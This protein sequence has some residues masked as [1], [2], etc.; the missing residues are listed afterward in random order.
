M[1]LETA[2]D[3]LSR[4]VEQQESRG[5]TVRHVAVTNDEDDGALHATMTVPVFLGT[6]ADDRLEPELPLEAT[7]TDDGGL[8]VEFPPSVLALP[9]TSESAITSR[10]HAVSITDD[11]LCVTVKLTI[12]QT[13]T[14]AR[15]EG[16]DDTEPIGDAP[17]TD[18]P[19]TAELSG[20]ASVTPGNHDSGSAPEAAPAL[21]AVRNEELPPY[22]DTDY[23]R[24]LYDTCETFSEMSQEIAMDVSSETVR[25]YMIDAGIHEPTSYQS[26]TR[27]DRESEDTSTADDLAAESESGNRQTESPAATD[28]AGEASLEEQI[29]TDG[30]GLPDHLGIE[31]VVEAVV[32]STT[33]YEVQRDLDL[34]QRPTR[35]LLR[36]LNLLDLVLHRISEGERDVSYEEV[37]TRIRECTAVAA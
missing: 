25:R 37:A 6:A 4:V 18:E 13:N 9:S 21:E 36:Q 34:E 35:E 27:N 23:L 2:F 16:A 26:Q 30:L 17:G 24:L 3:V 15:P 19:P 10:N 31:D 11:G 28:D 5:R 29:V 12:D 7:V 33:V 32:K 20:R 14:P 8:R 1:G 22:E